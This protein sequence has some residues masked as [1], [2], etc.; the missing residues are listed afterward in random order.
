MP[1]LLC[2]LSWSFSAGQHRLPAA[3]ERGRICCLLGR[4]VNPKVAS[5]NEGM[6]VAVDQIHLTDDGQLSGARSEA[7]N[8]L[9][10]SSAYFV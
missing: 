6:A 2:F 8:D 7:Q 10:L 1:L 5:A 9:D 4:D 3:A